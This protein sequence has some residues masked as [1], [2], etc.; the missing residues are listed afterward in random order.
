MSLMHFKLTHNYLK[1]NEIVSYLES[2]LSINGKEQKSIIELVSII[3]KTKTIDEID[4]YLGWVEK[5]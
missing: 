1:S 2:V 3:T 4:T 5:T